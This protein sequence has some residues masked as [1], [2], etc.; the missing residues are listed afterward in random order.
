MKK[1]TNAWAVTLIVFFFCI[2][3]FGW[4]AHDAFH[5]AWFSAALVGLSF[6][7]LIVALVWPPTVKEQILKSLPADAVPV[8]VS[9]D[10]FPLLDRAKLDEITTELQSLGFVFLCDYSV[11]NDLVKTSTAFARV[12]LHDEQHCIVEINQFF[13]LGKAWPASVHFQSFF[14]D[15][16]QRMTFEAR[17]PAP[18]PMPG[19]PQEK[20]PD[21]EFWR[22]VT[23]NQRPFFLSRLW[24][25]PRFIGRRMRGASPSKLLRTHLSDREK[26]AARLELPL[27]RDLSIEHY[28]TWC[29]W[30]RGVY[31]QQ[32]RGT[33]F[34][35]AVPRA[36]FDRR[37]EWW[38]ELGQSGP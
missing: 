31:R 29:H 24:R 32:L 6:F 7:L 38:G 9:P 18:L 3:V 17:K 28:F 16:P 8:P 26:I 25:H 37:D 19:A 27:A 21:A 20:L 23:H 2:A 33:N 4:M 15:G 14:G 12:M 36:F 13:P 5:L 22:Y 11:N 10:N 35:L 30:I 1:T 34:Y